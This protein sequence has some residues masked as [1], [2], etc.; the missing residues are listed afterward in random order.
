MVRDVGQQANNFTQHLIFVSAIIAEAAA[1][2]DGLYR[3]GKGER[4][5][6]FCGI[7]RLL[8]TDVECSV[9][10]SNFI[11]SQT[12]RLR[13]NTKQ[14]KLHKRVRKRW[15]YCDEYQ[16]IRRTFV[17]SRLVDP[18]IHTLITMLR[19]PSASRDTTR[20]ILFF[21]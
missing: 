12:S 17:W 1:I 19:R 14:L 3:F 5:L 9:A 8:H 21:A 6:L 18:C 7:R 20:C 2:N 13:H 4:A 10:V 16:S 11:P 15:D